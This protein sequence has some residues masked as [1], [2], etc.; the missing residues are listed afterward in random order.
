M[1]KPKLDKHLFERSETP[2]GEIE[3]AKFV[4]HVAVFLE[5]YGLNDETIGSSAVNEAYDLLEKTMRPIAY[6]GGYP[7]PKDH[8]WGQYGVRF[9]NYL[10][11][12]TIWEGEISVNMLHIRGTPVYWDRYKLKGQW[13]FVQNHGITGG[14]KDR[15]PGTKCD[16]DEFFKTM[17]RM[18]GPA[19]APFL[20]KEIFLYVPIED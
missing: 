1:D 14:S 8:F 16:R 11:A 9:G 10:V 19:I 2:I 12:V 13:Y 15:I 18:C 3:R 7:K 5:H 6:N 20:M 4:Q 17:I